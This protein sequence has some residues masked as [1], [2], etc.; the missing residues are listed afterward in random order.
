MHNFPKIKCF[1]RMLRHQHSKYQ[2]LYRARRYLDLYFDPNHSSYCRIAKYIALK[3]IYLQLLL[4]NILDQVVRKRSQTRACRQKNHFE[5]VLLNRRKSQ[6]RQVDYIFRQSHSISQ[7][8]CIL[9][10][11]MFAALILVEVRA[12]LN[13]NF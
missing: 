3:V 5:K 8:Y 6:S 10:Q 2:Y 4:W 11:M 7:Y 1:R 13:K 12:W 9:K